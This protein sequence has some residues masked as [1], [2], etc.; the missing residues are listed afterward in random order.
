MLVKTPS[1][2]LLRRQKQRLQLIRLDGDLNSIILSWVLSPK[3]GLNKR[4]KKEQN[5]GK[6]NRRLRIYILKF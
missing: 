2:A 5:D 4:L 3:G 1:G 6:W